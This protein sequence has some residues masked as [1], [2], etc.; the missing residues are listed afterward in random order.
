MPLSTFN[1]EPRAAA[2][3]RATILLLAS[4]V[5]LCCLFEVGARFALPRMSRIQNRIREDKLAVLSTRSDRTE[6]IKNVAI[7]GNSLLLWSIDFNALNRLSS[8]HFRYSRLVVEN[9]KYW[10][11]YFGL[12]HLLAEGARPDVVAI[13]IGSNHWLEDSVEGESFAYELLRPLDVMLL[14]RQLNLDR[15][16]ASTYFFVSGSSWLGNRAVIRKNLLR[17]IF[18]DFELFTRRLTVPPRFPQAEIAYKKAIAR[19]RDLANV[20][21]SYGVRLAIILHPTLNNR[22]P[23]ETIRDAAGIAGLPVIAPV[24]MDYASRL[25]SDGYHLNHAGM[26]KFTG[27]L[28]PQLEERLQSME[29]RVMANP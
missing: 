6:G 4:L 12:R 15:T 22:E 25:F 2:Y 1:S 29:Q 21:Q 14:R 23:F 17:L 8:G 16:T 28:S 18:P 24:H 5:L 19:M 7:V 10:D 27:D 26:K 20:C 3:V 9:T 11:W 13:L